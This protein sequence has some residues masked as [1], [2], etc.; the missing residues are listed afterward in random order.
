MIKPDLFEIFVL[1]FLI[2]VLLPLGCA[3]FNL[4]EPQDNKQ[5]SIWI[6]LRDIK[7]ARKLMY[8]ALAER[9]ARKQEKIGDMS[10]REF[11]NTVHYLEIKLELDDIKASMKRRK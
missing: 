10:N 7:E 4:P 5:T 1:G 11:R 2:I 3:E 6:E 8:S 9:E